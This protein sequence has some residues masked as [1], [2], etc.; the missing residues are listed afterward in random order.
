MER[1]CIRLC[2]VTCSC[3][4]ELCRVAG[5]VT[6]VSVTVSVYESENAV[7]S[8]TVTV[9]APVRQL[10]WSATDNLSPGLRTYKLWSLDFHL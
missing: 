2:L 8:V 3:T 10:S 5:A 9:T 1:D 6:D 4:V 7:S